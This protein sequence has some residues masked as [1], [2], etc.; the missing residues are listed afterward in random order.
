MYVFNFKCSVSVHL[1]TLLGR[2][3]EVMTGWTN[4]R[5]KGT[6]QERRKG[7]EPLNDQVGYTMVGI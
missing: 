3:R 2:W 6:R 1:Y 7:H 4:R 5:K